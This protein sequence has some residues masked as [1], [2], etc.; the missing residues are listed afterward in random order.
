[1]ATPLLDQGHF[2]TGI[3]NINSFYSPALKQWRIERLK[4]CANFRFI[5]RNIENL[6]QLESSDRCRYDAII[7]LAA[8]PGVRTS[9]QN[10][11][12]YMA[13]NVGGTASVLDF[14]RDTG[15]PKIVLASSSSVYGAHNDGPFHEDDSTDRP[16]SPYAASKKAC[17]GLGF[18]YHHLYN[19]DVSV[20][21]FF[22]VYGPAGRPDMS[23]FR[24]I[25]A[26]VEGEAVP[27]YGDG[28]QLRDFSYIDDIARGII[29]SVRPCG[30]RIFNLG[31][32]HPVRLLHLIEIVEGLLGTR[33]AVSYQPA[34]NSDVRATWANVER[35]R[36]ELD[37]QPQVLIEEGT[38]RS[39]QWYLENRS[40][41]KTI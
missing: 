33:V 15:T 29:A 11:V 30:Y 31:A 32:A 18:T 12:F 4:S 19:L 41:A 21:R 5:E 10:P 25:R 28:T 16:L 37:W 8:W 39:L 36:V 14:C 35:A 24:F 40:W 13:T 26:A 23:V 2:V 1:M 20:M 22:T 7:H 6:N 34:D 27:V 38:K 17:E 3:D 9:V